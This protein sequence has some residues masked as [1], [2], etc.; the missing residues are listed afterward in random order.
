LVVFFFIWFI[1]NSSRNF[2]IIAL[3]VWWNSC[4]HLKKFLW[5]FKS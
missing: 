2:Q 4:W 3:T 5:G 1:A